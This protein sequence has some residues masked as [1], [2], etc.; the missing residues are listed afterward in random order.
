[1]AST[2]ED[3]AHEK[4]AQNQILKNMKSSIFK[5]L[6]KFQMFTYWLSHPHENIDETKSLIKNKKNNIMILHKNEDIRELIR[7]CDIFISF[8]SSSMI[9]ALIAKNYVFVQCF[10]D[11]LT[12][13]GIV[14]NPKLC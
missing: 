13:M 2:Y 8:A 4:F 14:L 1:M 6:Q 9:D 10:L 11:G 12:V 3:K 7:I 5:N